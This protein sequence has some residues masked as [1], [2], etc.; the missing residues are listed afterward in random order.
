MESYLWQS[1]LL[2]LVAYFLGAV[3]GC[4][5]RRLTTS[6]ATATEPLPGRSAAAAPAQ[7]EITP[8]APDMREAPEPVQPRIET[9]AQPTPPSAAKIAQSARFERV[10]S[11]APATNENQE[12]VAAPAATESPPRAEPAAAAPGPQEQ[13]ADTSASSR[14]AVAASAAAIAAAAS[15]AITARTDTEAPS[16]PEPEAPSEP[17]V[18]FPS[19]GGSMG[20]SAVAAT[21]VTTPADDL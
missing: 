2:M 1:A 13:V 8:P 4:M 21:V 16:E 19:A 12:A 10:L 18:R 7:P 6:G 14:S 5:L 20:L 11:S 9:V 17:E 15:A 3:V